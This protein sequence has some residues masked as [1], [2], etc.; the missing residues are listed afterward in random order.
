MNNK[1]QI[2][3]DLKEL[4]NIKKKEK[5]EK[6]LKVWGHKRTE[7]GVEWPKGEMEEMQ[8]LLQ[9]EAGGQTVAE[10]HE[11]YVEWN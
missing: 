2:A 5:E 1:P 11:G 6:S 10:Q 8:K 7:K 3:S 9:V 4:L